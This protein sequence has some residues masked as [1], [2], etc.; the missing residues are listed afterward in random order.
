LLRPLPYPHP[1]ELVVV[2][3]EKDFPGG[4]RRMNFSA[5]EI[6]DWLRLNRAF[7]SVALHGGG[8]YALKTQTGVES[9]SGAYVSKGF[10][11]AL[12]EPLTLGRGILDDADP[13]VVI[14]HRLWRRRFAAD[15]HIVGKPL[16]LNNQS[17]SIIGVASVRASYP[18]ATTECVDRPW[19]IPP[20]DRH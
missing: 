10:F 19:R 12:G 16:V 7:A 13:V 5:S 6:E 3:A 9:V 15:P 2:V 8:A 14:S 11:S 20:A 18:R 4:T 1:D 17:H